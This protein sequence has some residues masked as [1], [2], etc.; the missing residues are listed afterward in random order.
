MRD[1][2]AAVPGMVHQEFARSIQS[3]VQ[4]RIWSVAFFTLGLQCLL[5]ALV[6]TLGYWMDGRDG[7]AALLVG[8][9]LCFIALALHWKARSLSSKHLFSHPAFHPLRSQL[10]ADH[11]LPHRREPGE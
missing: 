1:L 3:Q 2:L 8:I 9:P 5:G 4:H 7:H 10:N 6:W 11:R